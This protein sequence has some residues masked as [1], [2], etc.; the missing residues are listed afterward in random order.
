MAVQSNAF[1]ATSGVSSGSCA[2]TGAQTAGNTN[3]VMIGASNFTAIA[4]TSV[5][6][7]Q[8]NTPYTLLQSHTGETGGY[9][10]T[11]VYIATG[12]KAGS[13]TVEVTM[14][15][16]AGYC[17]LTIVVVEEG[18]SSGAR[19]SNL[20]FQAFANAYPSVSLTGTV[21]GDTVVLFTQCNNNSADWVSG[22]C[23]IGTNSG[24]DLQNLFPNSSTE[25]IV[26]AGD[27]TS[28]G[29]TV[30]CQSDSD[31]WPEEFTATAVALKPPTAASDL[32][33]MTGG[34]RRPGQSTILRLDDERAAQQTI[35]RQRDMYR[36]MHP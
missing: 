14:S 20:N 6:D 9:W 11:W 13:N 30:T 35:R 5:T 7:T 17:Y 36:E 33:P 19:V 4:P 2:F 8:G 26:Y 1:A 12:I 24:T 10:N 23:T 18:P 21:S 28:P 16:T 32:I 31:N 25:Y 27:G 15:G 22:P 3:V 34:G 29:G